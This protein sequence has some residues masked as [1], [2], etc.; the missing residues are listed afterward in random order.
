LI[1]V[2]GNG[3]AT[4]FQKPKLCKFFSMDAVLKFE[5]RL[6]LSEIGSRS[7]NDSFDLQP[8]ESY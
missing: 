3:I 1:L 8:A 2:G 6:I 5:L 7:K 4:C